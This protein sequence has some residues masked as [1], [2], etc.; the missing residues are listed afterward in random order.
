MN[1]CYNKIPGSEYNPST[2]TDVSPSHKN[3]SVKDSKTIER[4]ILDKD[5]SCL[6]VTSCSISYFLDTGSPKGPKGCLGISGVTGC[7]GPR[8]LTGSV[9]LSGNTGIRKTPNSSNGVILNY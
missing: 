9:G 7:A 3:L 8:G 4:K 2:N 6:G 5:V 1:S